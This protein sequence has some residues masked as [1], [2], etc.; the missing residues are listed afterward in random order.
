METTIVD[1]GYI[2]EQLREAFRYKDVWA[3]CARATVR[4][5][6]PSLGTWDWSRGIWKASCRT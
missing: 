1:W 2:D 6:Q 3:P 4:I 5:L